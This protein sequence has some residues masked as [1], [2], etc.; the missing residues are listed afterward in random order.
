MR[1][2]IPIGYGSDKARREWADG[3]DRKLEACLTEVAVE[4]IVTER[5][6]FAAPGAICH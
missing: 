6:A 2:A 4:V 5:K 3:P 1:L